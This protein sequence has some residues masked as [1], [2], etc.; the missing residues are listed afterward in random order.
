M[1]E[2]DIKIIKNINDIILEIYE[3]TKNINEEKFYNNIELSNI[4]TDSIFKINAALNTLDDELKEQYKNIDWNIIQ[5]NMYYDEIFKDSIK[6]NIVWELSN[7][8]L[9]K[10][11]Y[12]KLKNIIKE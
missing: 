5:N 6:L 1:K 7:N 2:K 8:I 12:L 3:K 9:Y 4:C 10:E 11:L